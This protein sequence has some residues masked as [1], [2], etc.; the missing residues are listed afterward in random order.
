MND[1][2][3][4][5]LTDMVGNQVVVGP[6]LWQPSDGLDSKQWYFVIATGAPY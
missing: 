1:V 6:L 5:L 4:Y 3:A 2:V